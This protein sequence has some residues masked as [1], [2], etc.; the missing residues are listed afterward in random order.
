LSDIAGSRIETAAVDPR[1]GFLFA[2][3]SIRAEAAF[4]Q[5]AKIKFGGSRVI[6]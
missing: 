2:P 4:S 6:G 3:L 1:G 5:P